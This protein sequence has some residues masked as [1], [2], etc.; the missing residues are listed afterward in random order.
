MDRFARFAISHARFTWLILA[1]VLFGGFS[2][3]LTQP[4]QEDPT[5]VVRTAQVTTRMP[6]LSPERVEQLIT[7]PIEQAVKTIPEVKEITSISMTGVSIVTPE[8]ESRY[9]DMDPIWSDLRNKMDD[10]ASELPSGSSDPVVNDDYGRVSVV[11]IAISGDD[12]GM[13][14]LREVARDLQDELGTLPLVARVDLFGVQPERIWIEF[15]P[16]FIVQ[17]GLNPANIVG[18]ITGQNIVLPG[19]TVEVEGRRIVIEPSGDFNSL[20][21]LRNISI[22]TNSGEVVYLEDLGTITRGYVDPPQSPVYHNGKPAVVLGIS[23]IEQSNVV[24][25]GKQVAQMLEVEKPKLPLG[26]DLEVVIFQPDLVQRSVNDATVNLLQTIAVVLFVVMVFLGLRMGFVVGALVPIVIMV[27]LIG[28]HLW[29]IELHRIS[30]AAIIVALGL[31]VDNGVVIAEDIQKR[32]FDGADRHEAALATPKT[33]ALPLLTS[34]LTTV[35]AF[36]PLILIEG[37]AG[38][39]LKSLGQVLAMALLSSWFLAISVTPALCYWFGKPPRKNSKKR[40]PYQGAAYSLYGTLLKLAL[41][42]RLV[43]VGIMVMLL[44]A[45]LFAFQTVKRR[46]LGPSERNQFVVYVDLTSESSATKTTEVTDRLTSYLLDEAHNP[47]VTQALAY[48]G[49]GGPRFFLSLSPNDPQPNKS[50]LVVNTEKPEQIFD[51]MARVDRFIIEGMP[52]ANGRTE[53]LA[54]SSSPQGTVELRVTGDKIG[55]MRR[56]GKEIESAFYSVP[57]VLGIRNDWENTV[58]KLRVDIDQDRARRAGVTSEDVATTL[59][60]YFDGNSITS[61]REGDSSIPITMRAQGEDRAVLGQIRTIEVLS[62]TSGVPVPLMQIADFRGVPET[63]KINRIDQLRTLSVSGVH[64]NLTAQELYAKMKESLDEIDLADG[65]VLT[66]EGEI[67]EQSEANTKLFEYAPH[68]FFLIVMLLVLQFNSIRRATIILLTIPL[69]LIG[70]IAGLIVF[71]AYF[72]F[73]A[74]LGIFSL[75]GI[76]INNGIVLIDRIDISRSDGMNVHDAIVD[77]GMARARPIIMTTATTILGLVPLALFGG[78][79]WYG[80]AIVI[81]AGLGVGTVLTLAFVPVMYSLLFR[82]RV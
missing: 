77:A 1:A 68:A 72:D 16:A 43:F 15:D 27:T 37:G 63:S 52:E 2:V 74:M 20:Q 21:E 82:D 71:R 31:L 80:M 44:V 25:L 78:E 24:E 38:E 54:L 42:H 19:G 33:L 58:V 75:A 55:E 3:Y 47:E 35:A 59:S 69:V 28:M 46:A 5:V 7:R 11:T 66:I 29:G 6:G 60:S 26:M 51:V 4:R 18:A 13:A 40:E 67:A 76:I 39:F 36:M 22:E 81:M 62:R 49:S 56:I 57:G 70:T 12:F 10:M 73:T 34:S 64:P 17:F 14:E 8:V 61:Y 79:F 45:S 41:R 9:T 48:I 65:N 32:V 30:I 50:F 23:M 53:V